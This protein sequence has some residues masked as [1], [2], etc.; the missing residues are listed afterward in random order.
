VVLL[1][2]GAA[3]T[4]I[5]TGLGRAMT[6]SDPRTPADLAVLTPESGDGGEIEISDLFRDRLVTRVAV[7]VPRSTIAEQELERR[8]IPRHDS[9][10]DVLARLGVPPTA[11][12]AVPA[13]E[14]G[15]TES[16]QALAVWCRSRA[17]SRILVIASPTHARRYR[18]ALARVWLGPGALP[19][20]LT[21][22]FNACR[23]D[24]WWQARGTLREGLGEL[25]KLLLDDLSHPL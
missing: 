22:R 10:V 16:T 24:T 18:R 20:I 6:T 2:G 9:P 5:L 21:T 7:L 12:V 13:G 1:V 17:A 11:I 4:A 15:T 23:A 19:A 3:R 25:A 8:G 14:G